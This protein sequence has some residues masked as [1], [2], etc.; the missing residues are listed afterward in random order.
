MPRWLKFTCL[1]LIVVA[2]VLISSPIEN[3]PPLEMTTRSWSATQEA[4]SVSIKDGLVEVDGHTGAAL[5]DQFVALASTM[6]SG[7]ATLTPASI[8]IRG[9]AL[10][11]SGWTTALDGFR[12]QVPENSELSL[13][14]FV[15]DDT[16]SVDRMCEK[17]FATI[18]D[19]QIEFRQSGIEIKSSSHASLDRMIGFAKDCFHSSI[20]ITGHSDASGNSD[21]NQIL[22]RQRAKAVAD[23]LHRGGIARDRLTVA[24]KGSAESIADNDT[25]QGRARNRRIEFE[26]QQ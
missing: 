24:G 13:D 18:N 25:A 8:Q 14:V 19:A 15:I 5:Q 9:V 12:R 16:L 6:R 4:F 21:F 26:L 22:S 7:H 23:Y 2:G 17:M 10:A 20:G 1:S 3:T 11:D